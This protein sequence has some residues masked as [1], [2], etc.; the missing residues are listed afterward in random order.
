VQSVQL[1]FTD[2]S[3]AELTQQFGLSGLD[4][5]RTQVFTA[6]WGH[7]QTSHQ[8]RRCST[9]EYN[10]MSGTKN[11]NLHMQLLKREAGIDIIESQIPTA[12]TASLETY[13]LYVHYILEHLDNLM[14]FYDSTHGVMRF[15]NYRGKQKARE[16]MAAMITTGGM[17]Y[18]RKKRKNKSRKSRR[19]RRNKERRQLFL[20]RPGFQG[21]QQRPPP[22]A[23]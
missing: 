18:D 19:R 16:A 3:P 5:G 17:K 14:N 20:P 4:P 21:F 8:V 11:R 2:F 10:A 1:E 7:G 13:Q 12:K 9:K 15:N 22:V 6:S 23:P